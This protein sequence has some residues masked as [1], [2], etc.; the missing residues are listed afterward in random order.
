MNSVAAEIVEITWQKV[1][2]QGN[3]I[4]PKL[5]PVSEEFSHK[6]IKVLE[7]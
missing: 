7:P 1:Q 6:K 5:S 2:V 4:R 3:H